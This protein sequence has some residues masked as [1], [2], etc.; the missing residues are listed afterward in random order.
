MALP[1]RGMA[2]LTSAG[3]MQRFP[4]RAAHQFLVPCILHATITV[5]EFRVARDG[6]RMTGE[7]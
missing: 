3:C 4:E 6:V 2:L 7:C 5:F 1:V